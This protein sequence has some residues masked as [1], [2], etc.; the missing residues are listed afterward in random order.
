[1]TPRFVFHPAALE[2]MRDARDR[3]EAQRTG[4]GLEFGDV[5]GDTLNRIGAHPQLYPEIETEVRIPSMHLRAT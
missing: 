5:I 3:Y 1:M 2:E 4:L